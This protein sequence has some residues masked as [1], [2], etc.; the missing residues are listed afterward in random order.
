[1]HLYT[2]LASEENPECMQWN[3][4]KTSIDWGLWDC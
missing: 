4:V 3:I 1:M 2:Y